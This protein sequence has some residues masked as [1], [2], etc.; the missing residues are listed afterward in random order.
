MVFREKNV[1]KEWLNKWELHRSLLLTF[2]FNDYVRYGFSEV[3]K[4]KMRKCHKH[5]LNE[6]H[7]KVYKKSNKKIPRYVVIEKGSRM[8]GLHS[9]MV[10]ETPEHLSTS[11]FSSLIKE[12]WLKTRDG[13]AT[14]IVETYNQEGL[15]DYLSKD[16]INLKNDAEIDI[17]NCLIDKSQSILL[18]RKC[19]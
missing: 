15:D 7:R 17:E 10:I 2:T 6:L 4:D 3:S 1:V 5:F 14:H 12:S 19:V 8:R 9:H 11:T 13:V 18:S 16:Q